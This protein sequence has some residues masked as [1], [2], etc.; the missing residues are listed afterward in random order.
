MAA[1]SVRF[2]R[3]NGHGNESRMP[4]H[5]VLTLV[6]GVTLFGFSSA[7]LADP[8]IDG[9]TFELKSSATKAAPPLPDPSD[10][11]VQLVLDDDNAEAVFGLA[12]SEARQFLWFNQ[13]TNPREFVLREI[14][15]L[16]PGPGDVPPGGNI[17]LLVYLD[18]D[19]DPANG[20]QLL[21]AYSEVIQE[22][23]GFNFSVYPLPAP[24]S[25]DAGGDVLIGVVNRYF[26]PGTPPP[27]LP[28]ALD[29]TA[30]LD[31]SYFA[32]WSGDVPP[33][34]DLAS[35]DT[36]D[37]L[38]GQTSGNFMIRGFGTSIAPVPTLSSWGVLIFIALVAVAGVSLARLRLG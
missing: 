38:D 26:T 36:I 3:H 23:D 1:M 8:D 32:L 37:V 13:F 25:I 18:P 2:A 24:L 4:K 27:T 33:S 31:R 35:A 12:G 22:A 19:G 6:V 11:P 16:F 10:F 7:A 14:W 5:L 15:V 30:S 28:A 21:G 20:A 29:T 17:E 9:L 34:P